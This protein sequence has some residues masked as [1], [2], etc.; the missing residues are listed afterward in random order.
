MSG[1]KISG[2]PVNILKKTAVLVLI[3]I[4]ILTGCKSTIESGGIEEKETTTMTITGQDTEK[5]NEKETTEPVTTPA[6][7][8][9]DRKSVV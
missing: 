7:Q 9:P 2:K 3:F 6:V 4:F 1:G 5:N 8:K